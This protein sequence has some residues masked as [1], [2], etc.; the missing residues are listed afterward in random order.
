MPCQRAPLPLSP[1]APK[2][3]E[4]LRRNAHAVTP[5]KSLKQNNAK[6]SSTWSYTSKVPLGSV[7]TYEI[8]SWNVRDI[9][10]HAT[11]CDYLLQSINFHHIV[12]TSLESY[13]QPNFASLTGSNLFFSHSSSISSSRSRSINLVGSGTGTPKGNVV[14]PLT[15]PSSWSSIIRPHLTD[16][17]AFFAKRTYY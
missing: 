1:F 7:L 4:Y 8:L 2:K 14:V 5:F 16:R 9:I 3:L 12:Q 13:T 15:L 6:N 17:P 10:L 11:S